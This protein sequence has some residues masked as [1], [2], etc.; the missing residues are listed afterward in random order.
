MT[1]SAKV[2]RVQANYVSDNVIPSDVIGK[3][4]EAE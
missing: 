3:I 1:S 4:N 2:S